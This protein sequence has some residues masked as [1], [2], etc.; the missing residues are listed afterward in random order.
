MEDLI[1]VAAQYG[2][3]GIALVALGW[4]TLNI[5]KAIVSSITLLKLSTDEN[6]KA[7]VKAITDAS[8][9]QTMAVQAMS[10]ELALTIAGA[11]AQMMQRIGE[12]SERIT[13]LEMR[14]ADDA[15]I[16]PPKRRE[17]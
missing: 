5:G 17:G 11:H 10:K 4:I 16:A 8:K 3:A 14:V 7:T 2:V 1:K 9:E 12:L 13:R 15:D 6:A